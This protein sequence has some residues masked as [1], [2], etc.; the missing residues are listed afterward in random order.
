MRGAIVLLGMIGLLGASGWWAMSWG[1]RTAWFLVYVSI[2]LLM[3]AVLVYASLRRGIRVEREGRG[4]G[5]GWGL[6]R[7][8]G[9]ELRERLRILA[10]ESPVLSYRLTASGVLPGVWL[11]LEERWVHEGTGERMTLRGASAAGFGR[12]TVVRC[13]LQAPGR[14]VYVREA[15]IVRASDAFGLLRVERRSGGG[16]Q[17]WVLPRMGAV[18]AEPGAGPDGTRPPV[19]QPQAWTAAAQVSGTRPYAPGDPLRRIHWRSTA[20]TGELRAKETELPAAVRQLVVLDAAG[21]GESTGAALWADPAL[22]AAVE[23]AAGIARRGLELGGR[24]RLAVSDG[25]GSVAEAQGRERF[26]ELLQLLA[27]V[28]RGGARPEAFAALALRESRQAGV[29][30]VTLVTARADAQ[31]A[32]AL[33]LLPRGAARVVF[34]H[35]PGALPGPVH[36]WKRQLES[37]GCRVTLA[38]ANG[39]AAPPKGGAGHALSGT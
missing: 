37:L 24:V 31:L 34:V 26:G 7:P 32:A 36:A 17:L 14:G 2:S 28:P 10:G 23:A 29:G 9:E 19:R 15:L 27:A 25:Q 4:P 11:M 30:A 5:A 22:A 35:G 16:G 18:A 38:P 33:R 1:G 3:Y 6:E 21:A 39:P 12:T 20:R 13:G 8:G